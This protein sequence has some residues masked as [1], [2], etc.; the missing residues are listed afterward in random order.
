MAM[1]EV[2]WVQRPEDD[3][4]HETI[5]QLGGNAWTASAEAVIADIESGR[6]TYFIQRHGRYYLVAVM[7]GPERKYLRAR[8]GAAW[9]DYLLELPEEPV[10]PQWPRKRRDASL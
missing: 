3:A 9:S 6:H 7:R 2:T 5:T 8:S 4:T 1:Y 10:A